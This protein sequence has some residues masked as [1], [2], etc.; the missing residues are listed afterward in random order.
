MQPKTILNRMEKYKSFVF[1][2]ISLEE[3]EGSAVLLV[4][5]RPR[6]DTGPPVVCQRPDTV[7]MRIPWGGLTKGGPR[8]RAISRF[9]SPG[10]PPFLWRP[11][12]GRALMSVNPEGGLLKD[13]A[14]GLYE[15]RRATLLKEPLQGSGLMRGP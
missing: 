15:E 8:F 12:V 1:G 10:L 4:T 9:A 5:I 2:R 13:L 14:G 7:Y 11:R 6:R 3:R